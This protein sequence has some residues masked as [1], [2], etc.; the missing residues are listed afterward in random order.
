MHKA[1]EYTYRVFWSEDDGEFVATVAEFPLLS[2][3]APSQ[4]KALSGIVEVVAAALEVY[5]EDGRGAPVPLGL[6]EYSG[7]LNLR[8]PPELHREIAMQASEQH[9]S[10]NRFINSKLAMRG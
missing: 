4:M 8:M 9:I 7:R 5:A 10:I 1:E 3:V 6:A 2:Y